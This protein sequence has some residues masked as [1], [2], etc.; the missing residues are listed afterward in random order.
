M[1]AAATM[2][3]SHQ[4]K[5]LKYT[6][7]FEHDPQGGFVATVPLLPGCVSQGES[8]EEAQV[9]IKDAIKGYIS[10]LKADGAIIPKAS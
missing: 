9:M 4:T 3:Q 10:V 6:V 8:F 1:I 7:F 5:L 2:K